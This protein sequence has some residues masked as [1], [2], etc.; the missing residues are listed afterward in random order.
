VTSRLYIPDGARHAV[1]APSKARSVARV[2]RLALS[3]FWPHTAVLV[4]TL[5]A[6][7][8]WLGTAPPAR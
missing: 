8:I 6:I 4:V 1:R 3:V 2:L 7:M 5:A